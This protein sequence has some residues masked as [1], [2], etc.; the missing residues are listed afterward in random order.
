LKRTFVSAI[1]VVVAVAG[2]WLLLW[3]TGAFRSLSALAKQQP[4]VSA[5]RVSPVQK[6]LAMHSPRTST[7]NIV[8]EVPS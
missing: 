8:N 2:F 5:T 6:K 4:D 1:I 7:E 3:A